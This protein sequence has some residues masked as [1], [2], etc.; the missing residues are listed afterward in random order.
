MQAPALFS[1]SNALLAHR[2]DAAKGGDREKHQD[3][4]DALLSFAQELEETYD[5]ERGVLRPEMRETY[6]RIGRH[7]EREGKIVEAVKVSAARPLP[8]PSNQR[9]IGH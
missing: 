5:E 4:K 8:T 9:L 7:A 1:R 3:I 6:E 2:S